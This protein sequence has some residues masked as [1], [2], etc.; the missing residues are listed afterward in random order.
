MSRI[1]LRFICLAVCWLQMP[2]AVVRS[3]GPMAAA[4]S[5]VTTVAAVR[6]SPLLQSWVFLV[7]GQPNGIFVRAR[8]RHEC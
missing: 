6:A 3:L 1:V 5:D 4:R 8:C 7:A 2:L